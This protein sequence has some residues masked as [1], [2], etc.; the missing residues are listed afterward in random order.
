M[1]KKIA[2]SLILVMLLVSAGS[3]PAYN[4]LGCANEVGLDACDDCDNF[5]LGEVQSFE[6]P[7]GTEGCRVNIQYQRGVDASV[8]WGVLEPWN[9]PEKQVEC[10]RPIY[11]QPGRMYCARYVNPN[12][13][14]FWRT[15]EDM[16][17]ITGASVIFGEIVAPIQYLPL[18][19]H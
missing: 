12:K 18:V 9:V 19:V 5:E 14:E 17:P 16:P 8:T 4:P 13:I 15:H 1:L 11:G 6:I 2:V 3:A 10:R 7:L